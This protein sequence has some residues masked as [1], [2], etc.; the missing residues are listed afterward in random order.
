MKL[1]E[2]VKGRQLE[3]QIIFTKY[4]SGAKYIPINIG[5]M[6]QERE[7]EI[8]FDVADI[9][10]LQECWAA[11]CKEEHIPEDCVLDAYIGEED[12][13]FDYSGSD[14]AVGDRSF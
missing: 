14:E 6:N 2:T 11:F 12:D 1:S 7:D 10:E 4:N 3:S 8:Q 9:T 5:F 13:D